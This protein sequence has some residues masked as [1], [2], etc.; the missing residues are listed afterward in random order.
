MKHPISYGV[1]LTDENARIYSKL[2]T[3][4][5]PLNG[6]APTDDA[7][8]VIS[9]LAHSALMEIHAASYLR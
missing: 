5:E 6:L 9:N 1:Y 2:N 7:F 8:E 4:K 3:S